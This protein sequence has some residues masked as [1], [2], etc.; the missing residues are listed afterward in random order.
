MELEN[1]NA[2]ANAGLT[3]GIIGTAGLL[4]GGLGLGLFGGHNMMTG[5]QYVTKTELEYSQKLAAKDSEIAILTSEQNTEVKIADTYERIMTR[6]NQD[7]RD[8][9]A[10]NASQSVINSQLAASIATNNSSISS[11]QT[12]I[13][14]L[15]KTV[16][17]ADSVC[18]RPMD[19]Y[20]SWTTPTSTTTTGQ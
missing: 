1:I 6:V 17:P 5:N 19:R 2:K 16:I 13:G 11:L 8:Q 7:Q 12:L 14:N 9:A 15:T 3:T 4:L 20:N 10:W 18:P